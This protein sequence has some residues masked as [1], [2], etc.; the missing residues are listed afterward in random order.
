MMFRHA[1]VEI[2]VFFFVYIQAGCGILMT[3]HMDVENLYFMR[4]P[5]IM[6]KFMCYGFEIVVICK[7]SKWSILIRGFSSLEKGTYIATVTT[8]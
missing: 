2:G 1:G 4:Y 7:V 5:E 3:F 6:L 8:G